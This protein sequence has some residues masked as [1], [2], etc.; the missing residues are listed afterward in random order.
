MRAEGAAQ[1]PFHGSAVKSNDLRSKSLGW[2]R[3]DQP[4]LRRRTVSSEGA[5]VRTELRELTFTKGAQP[6][7]THPNQLL[8]E[9]HPR[10][11]HSDIKCRL[12]KKLPHGHIL[13][14]P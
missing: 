14:T 1:P 10:S 2:S 7:T 12:R 13:L 9:H 6:K 5:S 11:Q 3:S 8:K 4:R